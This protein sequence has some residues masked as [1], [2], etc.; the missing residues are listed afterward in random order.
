MIKTIENIKANNENC[1]NT[2]KK[3]RS[4]GTIKSSLPDAIY[5]ILC[6][7]WKKVSSWSKAFPV[8]IATQAKGS[9]NMYWQTISLE[10]LLSISEHRLQLKLIIST[11][12]ASSGGVFLMPF[13]F[14][15]HFSK[16]DLVQLQ[17]LPLTFISF[18]YQI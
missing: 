11:K 14:P 8:P 17:Y 18:G 6:K 5:L 7:H 16:L 4:N 1:C 2:F 15:N 13:L 9:S 3:G 12:S 10:N